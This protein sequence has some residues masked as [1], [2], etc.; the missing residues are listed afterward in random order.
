M[1]FKLN[2]WVCY[3]QHGL[4]QITKAEVKEMFGKTQEFFTIELTSNMKIMMPSANVKQVGLRKILSKSQIKR[5]FEQ[6]KTVEV[7]RENRWEK[8]YRAYMEQIKSGEFADVCTVLKQLQNAKGEFELSFGERKMLDTA[9]DLAIEEV[10]L[11]YNVH[12]EQ[13]FKVISENVG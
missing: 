12:R 3:P 6:I 8:R 13:A 2:D 1:K 11:A 5:V 9:M 4:G 7:V 10:S